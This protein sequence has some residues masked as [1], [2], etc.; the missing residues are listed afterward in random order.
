MSKQLKYKIPDKYF[1]RLH[2]VRPRF[3]SDVEE[4]LLYVATSISEMSI[5]PEKE[6]NS[7]LNKVL[8]S[9]KNN[10]ISTQKT[11]DNWRTETVS[12]THLTLPTKR[13]V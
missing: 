6:F 10:S 9:F 5:L 12:Y 11:I 8:F 2:H 3:K 7:E 13:I 1:F 4:V